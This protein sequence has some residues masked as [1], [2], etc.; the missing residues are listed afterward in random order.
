[1]LIDGLMIQSR[2]FGFK[3]IELLFRNFLRELEQQLQKTVCHDDSD[4][5]SGNDI[6]FVQNGNGSD[7]E[8]E[9]SSPS[10]VVPRS[11]SSVL[12]VSMSFLFLG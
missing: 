1:M 4:S 9:F 10:S 11:R 8:V 3:K 5:E 12:A 6:F 7:L 2:F